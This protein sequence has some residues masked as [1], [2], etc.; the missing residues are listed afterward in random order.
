MDVNLSASD[1]SSLDAAIASVAGNAQKA[2]DN[3]NKIFGMDFSKSP[4]M[5]SLTNLTQALKDLTN[6]VNTVNKAANQNPKTNAGKNQTTTNQTNQ[7]KPPPTTNLPALIPKVVIPENLVKPPIVIPPNPPKPP[8]NQNLPV[9]LPK[10]SDLAKLIPK[11]PDPPKP[12]PAIGY[13]QGVF[14]QGGAGGYGNNSIGG[15]PPP[16]G[17]G[18]GGSNWNFGGPRNPNGPGPGGPNWNF[19]GNPSGGNRS[20]FGPSWRWWQSSQRE[21]ERDFGLNFRRFFTRTFGS[22]GFFG[23]MGGGLG[24]GPGGSFFSKFGNPGQMPLI[25]RFRVFQRPFPGSDRNIFSNGDSGNIANNIIYTA[26]MGLGSALTRTTALITDI[27]S[28]LGKTAAMAADLFGFKVLGR[29]IAVL[30]DI[31]G[32]FGD[33]VGQLAGALSSTLTTIA[34]A[35]SGIANRAVIASSALTE[36]YNAARISVGTSGAK[37]I[38]KT[39]MD[40][41]DSYGLSATDSMKIMTKVA[42]QYRNFTERSPAESGNVAS[43]LFKRMADAGSVMNMSLSSIEAIVQS[44]LAGRYTPLRRIGVG[45]SAPMLDQIAAARGYDKD[46]K[47]PFEGRIRALLDEIERQTKPFMEDLMHTQYEFANANRKMLGQIESAFVHLGRA[48]EPLAKILLYMANSSLKYVV[49]QFKSLADSVEKGIEEY[50]SSGKVVGGVMRNFMRIGEIL[51]YFGNVMDWVVKSLI[52]NYELFG[53]AL[54]YMVSMVW[55]IASG[56]ASAAISIAMVAEHLETIPKKSWLFAMGHGGSEVQRLDKNGNPIKPQEYATTRFRVAAEKFKDVID[57]LDQLEISKG[58]FDLKS[59]MEILRPKDRPESIFEPFGGEGKLDTG[60][61]AQFMNPTAF[62]DYVAERQVTFAQ[63][64]AENTRIIAEKMDT[65]IEAADGRMIDRE[66][67]NIS[68][69]VAMP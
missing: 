2:Y 15:P 54:K 21:F 39:A 22:G 63:Q 67:G 69:W 61:L 33:A 47:T 27:G 31:F 45:V 18:P 16:K 59:I 26:G 55:N 46:A 8:T 66:T 24:G 6:A 28:A 23:S 50:Y 52:Q 42:Q 58:P 68:P 3:L 10:P 65:F 20:R 5:A 12:P 35:F 37:G 32:S 48:I 64:T 1:I 30:T 56:L 44:A 14:G 36:L 17:P 11:P 34:I 4:I 29:T 53:T 7:T 41:Q 60:P 13:R 57:N 51:V 9:L 19:G 25:S 62:Y 40:Y 38:L 43:E 49:D